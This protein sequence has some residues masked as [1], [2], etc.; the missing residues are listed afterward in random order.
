[1]ANV[2]HPIQMVLA[3]TVEIRSGPVVLQGDLVLPAGATGIVLFAHGSGSSRHSSRNQYVAEVLQRAGFGTLLM[4][5]LTSDEE[6]IDLQTRHLRFDI[7][8]LGERLVSA[9][10]WL[11]VRDETAALP[12]GLFGASTGAGAVILAAVARP[13][14]VRAIVSRGGRPDLADEAISRAA[15]PTLLIVG[16]LDEVVIGLNQWAMDQLA[17]QKQIEIVPGATHLFEEPGTLERVATLARN[18]FQKWFAK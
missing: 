6:A 18:W 15:A 4:D 17:G 12:V 5:L 2:P 9:I 3:D 13:E 10:D 14:R 16:E 1:M 11:Q 8:L 7:P